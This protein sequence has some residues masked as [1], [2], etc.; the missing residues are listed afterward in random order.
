[1]DGPARYIEVSGAER[2]ASRN[3]D[4]EGTKGH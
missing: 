1:M 3:T 4:R 2:T